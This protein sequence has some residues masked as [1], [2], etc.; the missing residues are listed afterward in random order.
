M[1]TNKKITLR[2]HFKANCR[3]TKLIS[4]MLPWFQSTYLVHEILGAIQPLMILYF[5]A[6]L[7]DELS[8]TRNIQR[9]IL[10]AALA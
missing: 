1:E 6:Q 9:I 5:S 8:T 10:F 7:I 3:A 4:K 2:E